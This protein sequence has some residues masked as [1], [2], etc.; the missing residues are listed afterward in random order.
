[1]DKLVTFAGYESRTGP[2]IFPIGEMNGG[3]DQSI[4]LIKMARPMPAPIEQYVRSAKPIPNITQLLIDAMGSSDFYGSNVNGD[5]FPEEALAHDGD[6][7]GFRTFMRYAYPFKHHV[8]KDPSRAFGE[9]VTLSDWDPHMHRVLLIVQVHNDKCEDILNDL[10]ANRYWDVSMGCRVPFDYC[11]ICGNAAKT[12]ADYCP[13]LRYQMNRILDDGRRVCA[14][15]RQPKFFDISFVTI[16]AEKASHVL[17]KV[18]F[19]ASASSGRV[20]EIMSSA[21]AAELYY[22]KLAAADKAAAMDKQVPVSNV[23]ATPVTAEDAKRVSQYMDAASSVKTREQPIPQ[24]C[25]DQMATCGAGLGSIF[26]TLASLGIDLRPEEFQRI[27]IVKTAGVKAA[28]DVGGWVFDESRP[29]TTIPSWA[30]GLRFAPELV[31]EKIASIARPYMKSRSCHG[32]ILADRLEKLGAFEGSGGPGGPAMIYNRNSPWF[33][34]DQEEKRQ[35]SGVKG[36]VPASM[37]LAAGFMIFR[38]MFP[39]ILDNGPGLVAAMAKHPWL[40]PLLL[41]AGVGAASGAAEF[42]APRPLG[43]PIPMA[44]KTAGAT[45]SKLAVLGYVFAPSRA[46]DETD[47]NSMA[48]HLIK[49][50]SSTAG[51]SAGAFLDSLIF[52]GIQNLASRKEKGNAYSR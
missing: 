35:S 38:N 3:I 4:K 1:M 52:R 12:R 9:R 40:L 42:M 14:I 26:S 15:N 21:L 29:A 51:T 10:A 48:I 8:N 43:D 20:P 11:S 18:A 41:G 6:D 31:N 47:R 13:H 17:K 19:D 5:H 16:G 37:A 23:K 45:R 32:E 2:H 36:V 22:G 39:Q 33:P 28:N 25:L 49:Q 44:T 34:M 27:V 50:A 46:M 30:S 24:G 7:Y